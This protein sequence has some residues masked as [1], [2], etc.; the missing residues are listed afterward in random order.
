MAKAIRPSDA[1]SSSAD[2]KADKKPKKEKKARIRY[3]AL[4]CGPDKKA[5]VQLVDYPEDYDTSIHLPLRR[6][7]FTT[8]APYFR[9]KAAALRRRADELEKLAVAAATGQSREDTKKMSKLVKMQA[10]MQAMLEQ[11]KAEGIDMSMLPGLG[12]TK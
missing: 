2:K 4:M 12:G 5:T 11:L 10:A 9:R 3:P 7:D 1:V 6:L 8:D